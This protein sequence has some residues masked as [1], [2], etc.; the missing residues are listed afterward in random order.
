M[1]V[2]KKMKIK[3]IN[4]NNNHILMKLKKHKIK[5]KKVILYL[6]ANK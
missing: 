2:Y 6:L 5:K 4:F 1:N 3:I